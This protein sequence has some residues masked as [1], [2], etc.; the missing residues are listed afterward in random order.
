[1]FSE[2]NCKIDVT[3]AKKQGLGKS[4]HAPVSEVTAKHIEIRL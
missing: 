4:I 3:Y 1:M 2:H